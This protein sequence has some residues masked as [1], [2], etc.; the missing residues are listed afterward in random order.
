M[1]IAG[2]HDSRKPDQ[3]YVT[4]HCRNRCR[5]SWIPAQ[6]LYEALRETIVYLSSEAN[7]EALLREVPDRT[8]S[9][10]EHI[11]MVQERLRKIRQ[12]RERANR[13]YIE[14]ERL[15]LEEYDA[16]MTLIQNRQEQEQ[17][18]L[19]RLQKEL[20]AAEY[21]RDLE[22][23][24]DEIVASGLEK[25]DGPTNEANTCIRSHFRIHVANNQVTRIDY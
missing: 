11:E 4:Y 6:R 5:G 8:A 18:E 9:I 23:R 19:K 3:E 15:T 1:V 13:A 14:L 24:L 12:Q 22:A 20:R 2:T 16:Q 21:E 7:R 10:L 25:L 17:S